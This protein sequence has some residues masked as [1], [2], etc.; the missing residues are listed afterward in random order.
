MDHHG[1]EV[2]S[3]GSFALLPEHVVRLI[4]SREQ[5]NA[6]E[7]VKFQAALH[8]SQRYCDASPGTSDLREVIGNF[9]ECIEF[10]RIPATVLMREVHPL[11]VVPDTVMMN[12]LAF[13]A[14]PAAVDMHKVESP[15]RCRRMTLPHTLHLAAADINLLRNSTPNIKTERSA[16]TSTSGYGTACS[17]SNAISLV[18]NVAVRESYSFDRSDE[19]RHTSKENKSS[20]SNFFRTDS[21]DCSGKDSKKQP[22][23]KE[24]DRLAKYLANSKRRASRPFRR[25]KTLLDNHMG[26]GTS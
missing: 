9:F 20:S 8:W 7:L 2:L 18:G 23:E 25:A 6:D 21:K 26:S 3:L 10:Y 17:D 11:S 1:N 16:S 5:L 22:K 13:Q 4:L 15:N 19:A 24:K 14:D 12:A